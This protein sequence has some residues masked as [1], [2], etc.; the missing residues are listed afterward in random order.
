MIAPALDV[1]AGEVKT[2]R[3]W[4]TKQEIA[5]SVDNLCIQFGRWIRSQ[6]LQDG[7]NAV[8]SDDGRVEERLTESH[9]IAYRQTVVVEELNFVTQE[10]VSEAKSGSCK[11]VT[12]SRIH[13]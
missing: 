11:F 7:I 6:I 13:G 4:R 5:N 12:D 2:A 1:K 9:S 8:L 3:A 10:T